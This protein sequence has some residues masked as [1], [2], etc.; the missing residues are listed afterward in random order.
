MGPESHDRFDGSLS[1]IEAAFGGREA[2]EACALDTQAL[3]RRRKVRSALDL[4]RLALHYGGSQ[5]SLRQTAVWAG[6][7][8]GIRLSDVSL[9]ERFREMGDF[10]A[11]LATRLLTAATGQATVLP[12]WP[13]PPIRLTDGSLF[14]GPGGKGFQQR[15]HATYDPARQ[16][17][18]S[19]EVSDVRRGEALTR[20]GVQAGCL[21]VGDRNFS[22]TPALRVVQEEQAFF[23]TRAGLRSMCMVNQADG[24]RLSAATALQALG[25]G[26]I[27]ELAITIREAKAKAGSKRPALPIR[28]VL[29]RASAQ[30]A[31]REQARIKRSRSKFGTEPTAQTEQSAQMLMLATN[32]PVQNWPPE[33]VYAL[34]RLRWQIEL[35]FK[36]LKSLFQM[37]HVPANDPK[38]ARTWVLANLI[39]ALL[40]QRL[41]NTLAGA[42]SP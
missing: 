19:F 4:L 3:L 9:L 20:L 12:H 24:E 2:L 26:Q 37:R 21:Y 39:I 1:Q 40:S 16:A 8:L 6:V 18:D 41:C 34:Y 17:F 35:A 36:T 38:L 23:V 15:L 42:L 5:G 10:L 31:K 7:A 28:L 30:Q 33:R 11:V 25:Q 14:T 29:V 27:G 32:L 22:K 13:G